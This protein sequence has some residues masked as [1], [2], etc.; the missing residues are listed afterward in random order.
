MFDI[1]NYKEVWKNIKGYEGLYQISNL[2]NVKSFKNKNEKLL[3]PQADKNGYL[4]LGLRKEN[5]RKFY[6]IHRLVAQHFI[7]NPSN[8]KQ[9]N[10]IDGDKTNNVVSNLEWVNPVENTQHA[11]NNGL[12]E[13]C[14]ES[15]RIRCKKYGKSVICITTG[16]V[17]ISASEAGRVTNINPSSISNCCRGGLK[18]AGK[19]SDGTKLVWKYVNYKHNKKYRVKKGA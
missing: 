16:K 10:H 17:F 19:L 2:G 14:R 6:S 8:K 15:S 1:T 18:S 7:D 11:W 12:C 9:V 4:R 5:N 13:T 3:K